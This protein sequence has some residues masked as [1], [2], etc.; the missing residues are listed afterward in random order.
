MYQLPQIGKINLIT[1]RPAKGSLVKKLDST[2]ITVENGLEGDYKAGKGGNRLVTLFQFEHLAVLSTILEQTVLP[3]QIRRNLF[4]SKINLLSLHNKTFKIGKD[5]ILQGT[6]YC[7]PCK[8]MEEN[9]GPGGYY[10][11]V[12]HGGLT[13]TVISGGDITLNDEVKIID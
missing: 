9:L 10:A 5:I 8:K 7:V 4:V 3:E 11:M 2:I 1:V 6:G 12:G 13:A